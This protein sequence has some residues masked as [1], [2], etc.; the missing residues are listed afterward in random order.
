MWHREHGPRV[1]GTKVLISGPR[2]TTGEM[3]GISVTSLSLCFF[4]CKVEV[5]WP[6]MK[7]SEGNKN[8]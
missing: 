8:R 7:R 1:R 6:T 2:F 5:G 4:L 3:P